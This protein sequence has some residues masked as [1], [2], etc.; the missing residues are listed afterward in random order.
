MDPTKPILTV[1]AKR[2]IRA[3]AEVCISY[4]GH[5]DGAIS[6]DSDSDDD[7][8]KVRRRKKASGKQGGKLAQQGEGVIDSPCYCESVNCDGSACSPVLIAVI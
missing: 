1:F 8:P 6:E 2:K 5:I 7:L 4:R 3:G